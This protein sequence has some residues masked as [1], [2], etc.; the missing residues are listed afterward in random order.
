MRGVQL[1]DIE[2]SRDLMFMFGLNDTID[3][4]SMANSVCWHDHVLSERG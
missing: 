2:R 1:K 4:L 3:Q